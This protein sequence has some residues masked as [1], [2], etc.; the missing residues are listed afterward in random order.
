[1]KT[2][3]EIIL[4]RHKNVVPSLD[5]IRHDVVA[6]IGAPRISIAAKLW[7]ELIVP[8]RH[9]WIGLGAAWV[10]VLLLSLMT[11]G[12]SS[13]RTAAQGPVNPNSVIALQHARNKLMAKLAE[14][15]ESSSLP[16]ETPERR[17]RSEAKRV[18]YEMV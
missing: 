8:V 12:D 4:G 6:H 2:P 17:P 1:M 16:A 14:N 10:V 3:R 18:T 9:A 7:R 5:Q 15:N 11:R 13:V